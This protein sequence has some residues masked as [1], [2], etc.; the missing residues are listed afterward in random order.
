MTAHPSQYTNTGHDI[1]ARHSIQ[2]QDI[3]PHPSQYTN[4]GNDITA[5]HS[6]KAQEVALYPV[7]VH[8]HRT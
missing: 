5:R 8:I 4:T 6:L 7:T 3:T 2:T 1:T